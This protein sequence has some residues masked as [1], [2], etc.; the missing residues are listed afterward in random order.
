MDVE[1]W[2]TIADYPT[3]EV[4]NFGRVRNTLPHPNHPLRY[5]GGH[6]LNL[7]KDKLN[8]PQITL[9]KRPHRR[10]R[11]VHILVMEAFVGSCPEGMEIDHLDSDMTNPRLDN[12]EYVTHVENVRRAKENGRY[13]LPNR[14]KHFWLNKERVQQIRRWISEGRSLVSITKHTPVN[15]STLSKIKR[16]VHYL[17]SE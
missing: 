6:V 16:G 12:L 3:F 5:P 7:G 13:E 2:R 9:G 4:S 8:R 15:Y 17:C 10:C 11:K 14:F 1:V